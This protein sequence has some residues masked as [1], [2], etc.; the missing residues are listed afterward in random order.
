MES[1]K[2]TKF[3]QKVKN[4]MLK[5]HIWGGSLGS[6]VVLRLPL[7]QGA[8]LESRDPVLRQAPG[9]EPASSFA[10]VSASLSLYVYHE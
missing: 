9:M 6:S 7:S 5:F 8:I 2:Q 1:P 10:C 3:K 4:L